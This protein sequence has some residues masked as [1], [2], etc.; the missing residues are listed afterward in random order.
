M[1]QDCS[2]MG[3][4][5]LG[6]LL[7]CLIAFQNLPEGFNS[8]RELAASSSLS[9]KKVLASFWLITLVGPFCAYAGFECL[10]EHPSI[11]GSI[12]LAAASGIIY[13]T[14]KD[15]APQAQLESQWAPQLGAVFGFLV[16]LVGHVLIM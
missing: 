16:G 4:N 10:S 15:I 12:M 13:L 3:S 6:M 8:Y 9:K 7:A 14:F 11:L 2:G 5:W 1:F